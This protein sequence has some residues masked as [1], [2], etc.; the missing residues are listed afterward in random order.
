VTAFTGIILAGGKSTRL[1]T[2]KAFLEVGEK[3]LIVRVMDVFSG[4]FDEVLI[5]ANDPELYSEL[6]A[7]VALD[8]VPK[9]GALI[10][11]HSSLS[12]M[13]TEYA[14]VAACDMPFLSEELI[15]FMIDRAEGYDALVPRID[16]YLEPLHAA[17][18]KNCLDAIRSHI[19]AGHKHLRSFYEDIRIG[20]VDK[21]TVERLDPAGLTFFNINTT[22]DLDK[23]R[24]LLSSSAVTRQ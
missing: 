21:E 5:S 11:L 9:G 20:Y 18:S 7:R 12:A 23:A 19:D 10:G 22:D 3:P 6:P 17:Y 8:E 24:S 15:R 13:S 4:L 14:F 16:D 2:E 1:G